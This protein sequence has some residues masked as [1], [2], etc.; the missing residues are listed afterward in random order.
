G[1]Y[2]LRAE[3]HRFNWHLIALNQRGGVQTEDEL[4]EN[5]RFETLKDYDD[6]LARLRNLPAYVNQTIDLLREGIRQKMV[7]PRVVMQRIP[8]QTQKQLVARP[9]D[10]GFFRP[11]KAIP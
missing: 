5:L 11:L 2:E 10:S 9:E 7:L 6:W 3:S 4:A 1:E 8:E